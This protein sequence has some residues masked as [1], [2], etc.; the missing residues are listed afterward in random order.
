MDD[1]CDICERLRAEL[2]EVIGNSEAHMDVTAKWEEHVYRDH[3][4]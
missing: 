3:A 2:Q 4:I 1:D